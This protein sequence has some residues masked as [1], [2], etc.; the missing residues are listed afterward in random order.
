MLHR[1]LFL[2]LILI[3]LPRLMAGEEV[4]H[5]KQF[6]LV[7]GLASGRITRVSKDNRFPDRNFNFEGAVLGAEY[8]QFIASRLS[9]EVSAGIVL[10]LED[11]KVIKSGFDISSSLQLLGSTAKQGIEGQFIRLAAASSQAISITLGI[12]QHNYTISSSSNSF[13]DTN[14]AVLA[15]NAGARYDL[16]LWDRVGIALAFW[17]QAFDFAASTESVVVDETQMRAAL[18]VI[19]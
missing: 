4:S 17:L 5:S 18:T 12:G 15:I 13:D 7:S 3:P 6:N 14:G 16:R 10:A 2:M 19:L 8:Q 9:Y 11:K 1:K